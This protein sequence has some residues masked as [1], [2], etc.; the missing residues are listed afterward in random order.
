MTRRVAV[1]GLGVVSALGLTRD[2]HFEGLR[3]GRSGI[4][5]LE[6]E[7]VD[8]LSVRIGGQAKG[9]VGADRFDRQELTL[10]D[11][12]TQLAM[13][14]AEEALADSG[15]ALSEEEAMKRVGEQDY[16][17]MN[18]Y[19]EWVTEASFRDDNAA[20]SSPTKKVVGSS[21][22]SLIQKGLQLRCFDCQKLMA[23]LL[24]A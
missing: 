20:P 19:I 7:D 3:E 2:A 4:G 18:I 8:R 21:R 17:G 15:I 14:A 16:S 10:F 22:R 1:T 24:Q 6:I 5:D 23:L 9:F 11:R 12:T 13:A